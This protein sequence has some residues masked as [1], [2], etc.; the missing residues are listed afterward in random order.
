MGRLEGGKSNLQKGK[1]IL[2]V[3]RGNDRKK[4]EYINYIKNINGRIAKW[5]KS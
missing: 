5:I 1:G 4:F 2:C 3:R